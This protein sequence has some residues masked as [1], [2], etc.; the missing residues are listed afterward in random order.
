MENYIPGDTETNHVLG[1]IDKFCLDKKE[2]ITEVLHVK[3][4]VKMNLFKIKTVLG[5]LKFV[6]RNTH[7]PR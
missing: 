3:V 6:I 5:T 4:S 1:L 2:Y 7:V